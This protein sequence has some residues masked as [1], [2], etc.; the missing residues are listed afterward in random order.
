MAELIILTAART[1]QGKEVRDNMDS[2]FAKLYEDLDGG[3]TPL[4]FMFPNLPLPSY[5]RRDKAQ[6][7]MSDFYVGIMEK[8]RAG[9]SDVSPRGGRVSMSADRL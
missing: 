7:A 3:F 9:E 8:R 6:K 4:N 5:R 1:L 2:T